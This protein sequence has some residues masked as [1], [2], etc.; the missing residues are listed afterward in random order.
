LSKAGFIR[1]SELY[2]FV[3]KGSRLGGL[4]TITAPGVEAH[5]GSLGHG[6]TIAVGVALAAKIRREDYLT[7]VITGD[8]ECQE[9][10]IWEAAASITHYKLNN[11]IWII[12][13]NDMQVSG[14]IND[15]MSLGNIVMRLKSYGFETVDING[16]DFRQILTALNIDRQNLPSKPIVIIAQTIKGKGVPYLEG[17][18]GWHG[19]KPTEDEM[20]IIKR[21]IEITQGES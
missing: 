3:K 18:N 4:T 7:Y 6:L 8:G 20:M 11:L 15:V 16:H 1:N 10:S 17:K 9:G 14:Y 2:T 19:R 5:T 21:E 12:D 13:K